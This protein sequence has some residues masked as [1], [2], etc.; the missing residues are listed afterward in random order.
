MS[1]ITIPQTIAGNGGFERWRHFL[2]REQ[3]RLAYASLLGLALLAGSAFALLPVVHNWSELGPVWAGLAALLVMGRYLERDHSHVIGGLLEMIGMFFLLSMMGSLTGSVLATT[4]LPTVDAALAGIDAAI[5]FEWLPTFRAWQE[6][7]GVFAALSIVYS[8]LSW[9]PVVLLG[10]LTV[11]G[12]H[13]AAWRFLAAWGISLLITMLVFPFFPA[14]ANFIVNGI[15]PAEVPGIMVPSGWSFAASFD[16]LRDGS[17]LLIG[18][19]ELDGLVTFPS[20]HTSAG[21]LLAAGFAPLGRIAWPLCLLNAA[22]VVSAVFIGAHYLVD[23]LAGIAIALLGLWV[24]EFRVPT[25]ETKTEQD[26]GPK[27]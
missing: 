27:P 7:D 21:I 12:H 4:A 18:R 22:M 19:D 15:D 9:Q 20:F 8:S 11:G 2:P 3:S 16:G 17:I 10:L 24:A 6:V 13:A 25:G 26:F 14:H 1:P 5:G 23:I